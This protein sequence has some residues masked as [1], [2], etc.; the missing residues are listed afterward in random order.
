LFQIKTKKLKRCDIGKPDQFTSTEE[1]V[2]LVLG[3]T[4][5]GKTTL[6]NGMVNYLLGVE[7]GDEF[8]FKLI[9]NE[10]DKKASSDTAQ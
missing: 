8:R 10:G 7:W 6:I 9:V 5:A 4:G 3:A 1:K 2:I